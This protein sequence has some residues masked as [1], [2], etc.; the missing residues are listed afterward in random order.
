MGS[1]AG[2]LSAFG[3]ESSQPVFSSS[4]YLLLLTPLWSQQEKE[5][6]GGKESFYVTD[7]VM[8]W[9]CAVT[10]QQIFKAA[11]FSWGHFHVFF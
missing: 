4:H 9:P 8:Q 2:K 10:T 11:P 1:V 6:D 3:N 5:W 7:T